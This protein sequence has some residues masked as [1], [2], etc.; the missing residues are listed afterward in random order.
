[1]TTFSDYIK[2]K[3]AMVAGN[4]SIILDPDLEKENK[5]NSCLAACSYKTVRDELKAAN[6]TDDEKKKIAR[7]AL[8]YAIGGRKPAIQDMSEAQL[9]TLLTKSGLMLGQKQNDTKLSMIGHCL[10]A[11]KPDSQHIGIK[12]AAPR[13][14]GMQTKPAL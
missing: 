14:F 2:T 10:V 7:L 13:Q 6:L 12:E 1:M 9:F 4:V 8:F 3:L 11:L 5:K